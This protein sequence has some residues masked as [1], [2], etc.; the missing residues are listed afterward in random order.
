MTWDICG[1]DGS[2]PKLTVRSLDFST[3]NGSSYY[4][5][6]LVMRYQPNWGRPV[7]INWQKYCGRTSSCL[8]PDPETEVP[9]VTTVDPGLHPYAYVR[10][11][12]NSSG[13]WSDGQVVRLS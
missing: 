1:S 11:A 3:L 12:T 6:L 8:A 9:P 13:P 5:A 4:V 7:V 2:A 10:Y